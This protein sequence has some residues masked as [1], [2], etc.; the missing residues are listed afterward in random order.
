MYIATKYTLNF[1]PTD[2]WTT[3]TWLHRAWNVFPI[4]SCR[5]I[6]AHLALCKY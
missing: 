2:V 3:V 1:L 6:Q 5:V 4:L